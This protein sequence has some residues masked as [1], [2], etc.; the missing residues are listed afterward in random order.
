MHLSLA[1]AAPIACYK[2]SAQ[3][4]PS[5]NHAFLS[6]SIGPH[7]L[8]RHKLREA[9]IAECPGHDCL[10]CCNTR[11]SRNGIDAVRVRDQRKRWRDVVRPGRATRINSSPTTSTYYPLERNNAALSTASSGPQE[12]HENWHPR[13]FPE[14]SGAGTVILLGLHDG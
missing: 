13:G 8:S 7:A 9:L 5:V 1:S 10:R 6:T 11:R 4:M 2:T 14:H 12:D 3:P